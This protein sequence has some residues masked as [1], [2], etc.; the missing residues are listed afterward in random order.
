[1][2]GEVEQHLVGRL[3]VEVVGLELPVVGVLERVA[4][5]DAEKRLVGARVD[6]AQ[7][8]HIAGRDRRQAQLVG[9]RRELRQD[10]RLHVEVGVLQLDVDVVLPERL[11]EPVELALG[12]G[13]AVL[14]ER[15]ADAAREAAREGDQPGRM[16]L[17][18]LPVDARLV[19]VALEVAERRELDQVRVAGVVGREQGQV[20]VA[21]LV[22]PAVR[23]DVD[24][25]ADHGLD[26]GAARL[27]PELH[28]ASHRA[29]IGQPDRRHLEL[30]GPRDEVGD[31]ARTVENGVLRVDVEVDE[32]RVGH[33]GGSVYARVLTGPERPISAELAAM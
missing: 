12:V 7:V 21:L 19:V 25:A 1:M 26:P 8:V 23:G 2:A 31:P 33:R 9:Q 3:E 16:A 4:G 29:V 5:L 24:L 18:Q 14:L 20:R 11:R 30:G 22:R 27:L 28:R 6:V 10:A 17:E 15:L 32:R 13:D